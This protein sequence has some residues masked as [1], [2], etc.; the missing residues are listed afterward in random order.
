MAVYQ[1]IC[2]MAFSS[3]A[4]AMLHAAAAPGNHLIKRVR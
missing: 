2:G 3:K 1:C 4:I